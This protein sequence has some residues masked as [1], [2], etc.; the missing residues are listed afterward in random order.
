MEAQRLQAPAVEDRPG[1]AH[2]VGCRRADGDV[3]RIGVGVRA[4]HDQRH[5]A[6][7]RRPR[8]DDLEDGVLGNGT[9]DHDAVGV[10]LEVQVAHR[11][12]RC[13][14]HRRG[15][16]GDGLDPAAA[17]VASEIGRDDG[18]VAD[19]DVAHETREAFVGQQD[20]LLR[21]APPAAGPLHAVHVDHV[22]DAAKARHDVEDARVVAERQPD[23][24]VA[25]VLRRVADGHEVEVRGALPAV[26]RLGDEDA[27]DAV[28]PVGGDLALPVDLAVDDDVPPVVAQVQPHV[29]GGGLEPAVGGR[30]PVGAEDADGAARHQ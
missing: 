5:P 25:V 15:A 22:R 8:G 1:E 16:V 26:A 11:R 9:A 10:G 30:H 6:A 13:R 7:S 17:E 23:V 24:A 28:P 14:R 27:F 3:I 20:A 21:E 29:F 12:D 18:V 2:L 4:H 19:Q